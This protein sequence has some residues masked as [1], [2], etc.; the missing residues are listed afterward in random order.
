M[1]RKIFHLLKN[2]KFGKIFVSRKNKKRT[3]K[4]ERIC[5][6]NLSIGSKPQNS[7]HTHTHTHTSSP[8]PSLKQIG[9]ICFT[10]IL[11]LFISPSYSYI[12]NASSC[13][14]DVLNTTSAP[15]ALEA[16]YSANTINTKWYSDGTQLTGTGI[17]STCTYDAA[18]SLPGA[19]TKPGYTFGGW[20][21]HVAPIC[22]IPY[23]LVSTNGIS[24][25]YKGAPSG[26]MEAQVSN[27]ADYG[28][29]EEQTWGVTWENGDK[30]TGMAMCSS[31][32]SGGA[33]ID[34]RYCWCKATHY[35]ANGVSQCS[36]SSPTW[37]YGAYNNSPSTCV[38]NCA[39]QCANNI[40]V[41]GTLR[42]AVFAGL[43]AE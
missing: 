43:V 34:A 25:G 42:D 16:N 14:E 37:V 30:V 15:A 23:S 33:G 22:E 38:W 35:T 41:D 6:K 19:Q 28:L 3:K 27:T 2:L 1:K 7:T 10:T 20:R 18:I 26:F 4:G 12:T 40:K 29:T 32:A 17:P 31:T 11:S 5:Q 21:V 39:L 24:S 8:L 9:T 36:L 13:D